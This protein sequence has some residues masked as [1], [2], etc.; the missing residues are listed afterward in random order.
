MTHILDVVKAKSKRVLGDTVDRLVNERHIDLVD[1]T[2]ATVQR[3][4]EQIQRTG[5]CDRLTKNEV[6]GI[7]RELYKSGSLDSS[8]IK[9]NL[10]SEIS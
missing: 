2:A 3:L 7:L 8:K 5:T 6:V 10:L 9:P 1:L 4:A